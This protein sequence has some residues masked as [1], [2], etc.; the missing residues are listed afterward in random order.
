MI[1]NPPKIYLLIAF[2]FH[3][4]FLAVWGWP[5][6]IHCYIREILTPL[7][8][9]YIYI[10]FLIRNKTV[11]L[12]TFTEIH[13]QT[14]NGY[15]GFSPKHALKQKALKFFLLLTKFCHVHFTYHLKSHSSDLSLLT[16]A[17]TLMGSCI[18][19][20]FLQQVCNQHLIFQCIYLPGK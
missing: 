14:L 10:Y 12:V 8:L 20:F 11:L 13:S 16:V 15:V 5:R 9:T 2:L 4:L 1:N 17:S 3:C 18:P 7:F 19:I 6:T